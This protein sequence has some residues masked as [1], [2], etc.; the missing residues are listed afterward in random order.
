M[1]ARKAARKGPKASSAELRSLA[2]EA[3]RANRV[4]IDQEGRVTLD[5]SRVRD[6]RIADALADAAIARWLIKE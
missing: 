1:G 6:S 3:L 4:G 2:N 5:G